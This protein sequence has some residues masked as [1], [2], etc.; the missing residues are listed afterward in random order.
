MAQTIRDALARIKAVEEGLSITAP[1]AQRIKRVYTYFPHQSAMPEVPCF[2]HTFS[3]IEVKHVPNGQRRQSYIVRTQF[4]SGDADQD[5]AADIATA[6]LAKW[7]DAFSDDL[8][9]NGVVEG[10]IR[11]RGGDPT[12]AN[13]EFAGKHYVG[14]DL[15][16]EVP[17]SDAVPVGP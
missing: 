6:F 1:V 15:F 8:K 14:L 12:L 10:Q 13:L 11:L 5:R 16:I 7:L 4:L 3:L 9:L 17:M 2:M